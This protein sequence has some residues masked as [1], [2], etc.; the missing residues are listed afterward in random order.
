MSRVAVVGATGPTG[1]LVVERA[2]QTG[3]DVVVYARRPEVL[4]A[5]PHLTVVGGELADTAAFA[6]A[7]AGCDVLI[8]TLGT[9]SWRER[10]FMTAHLPLVTSAMRQAGV[11]RLILMSALGGG[12]EPRHLRGI[13]RAVFRVLSRVVFVDRTRSEAALALTG[14]TWSA[15][16]PGFL[17][18]DPAIADVDLVD[19]D[20]VVNSKN[21]RIPRANVAIAL[22]DLVGDPRPQRL[23]IAPAGCLTRQGA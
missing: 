1:R 23:I 7:I 21:S 10:G 2:L 20:A 16:Y 12:E 14:I 9:R 6:E 17:T 3:H 8:C 15:V 5:S 19:V 18:D 11:G 4:A 13:A 22:V